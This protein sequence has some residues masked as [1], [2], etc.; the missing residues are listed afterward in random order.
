MSEEFKLSKVEILIQQKRFA[1]AEGVLM[2]LLAGDPNNV[3]FLSL[4]AEVKLQQD[5][6]EEANSIIG[7]AI[8]LAPDSSY[9]FYIRARIALQQD[10]PADAEEILQHAI[11][12]DPYDADYFALLSHIKT[13]RKQFEEGLEM[14]DRALEIDAENLMALN[15]RSRALNKLNRSEESFETIEGALREDPNN[16]FTHANY[17]WGLL[18]KGDHKKALEHFK[19][20]LSADPNMSYAQS[21]MMEALK[22]T[23][24]LYRLFL[25][26][27]FMMSRLASKYQWG[28][29]IGFYLL[30]RLLN[31]LARK[32]EALE[33]YLTPVIIALALIAFS[34]WIIAPISN[35]FL[36]FNRYGQVLLDKKEKMSSNFVAGA[37]AVFAV[38][39]VLYVV[40][41]DLRFLSVAIFG[42]V[43]MVP[44]SMMFTPSKY[45]HA[46]LIY[47]IAMGLVGLVAVGM[48]FSTGYLLHMPAFVFLIGFFLFQ[49]VANFLLIKEDNR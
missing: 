37:L 6:Y 24:P 25:K 48:T 10:R 42:F 35:L 43:M 47:S 9:L 20:A 21:G 1:E 36:R 32:N 17:G 30:V 44:F 5:Q 26:Y 39:T 40:L 31:V 33:P 22:A 41:H 27:A 29:I 38:G 19:E 3:R 2:D 13:D 23:N 14:A 11:E 15:A 12:L 16:A 8:G 18:E 7:Q 28:V 45:N 49:W 4:M 46:F 34:T